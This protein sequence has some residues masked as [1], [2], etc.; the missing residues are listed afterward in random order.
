MKGVSRRPVT[1]SK[2]RERRHGT[3]A[4]KHDLH[5]RMNLQGK[6]E[7]LHISQESFMFVE[8]QVS[9]KVNI[10]SSEHHQD[11]QNVAYLEKDIPVDHVKLELSP[12][13]NVWSA[14]SLQDHK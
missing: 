4:D 6:K 5:D 10:G 2:Q 7:D 14:K 9:S 1:K 11:A 8:K 12:A 3:N 13:E